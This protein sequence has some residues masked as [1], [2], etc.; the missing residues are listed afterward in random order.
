MS[1]INLK[2]LRNMNFL[3]FSNISLNLKLKKEAEWLVMP[4][5]YFSGRMFFY[6]TG[7]LNRKV[8]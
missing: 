8:I 2:I 4:D 6:F 1:Q 3:K 5:S 7:F